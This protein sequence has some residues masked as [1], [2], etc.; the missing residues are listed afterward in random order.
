MLITHAPK[1]IRNADKPHV[2]DYV[3]AAVSQEIGVP[4]ETFFKPW[5]K[6]RRGR[7]A[8]IHSELEIEPC[9]SKYVGKVVYILDDVSTTN[10]TLMTAV[11]TRL[12]LE[13]HAHGIAWVYYS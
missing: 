6:D 2:I 8:N 1:S 13:I 5:E 10:R 11:Q 4:Y 3:C 12:T 9:V 7:H